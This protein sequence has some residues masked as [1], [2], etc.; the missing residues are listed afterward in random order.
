VDELAI[1]ACTSHD[2]N[3]HINIFKSHLGD[4]VTCAS[5]ST[6]CHLDLIDMKTQ[7]SVNIQYASNDFED[8]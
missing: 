5:G 6:S 3:I 1:V 2:L 8:C 7:I 4:T